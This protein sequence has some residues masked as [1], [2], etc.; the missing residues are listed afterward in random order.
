MNNLFQ[1][2]GATSL[3][4]DLLRSKIR[5]STVFISSIIIY[6]SCIW[7]GYWIYGDSPIADRITVLLSSLLGL[8]MVTALWVSRGKSSFDLLAVLSF[9]MCL[10]F[11]PR[12]IQYVT[13]RQEDLKLLYLL[14]PIHWTADDINKGL[15]YVVLGT[16]MI[17]IGFLGGEKLFYKCSRHTPNDQPLGSGISTKLPGLLSIILAGVI[18]Y[19]VDGYYTIYL[20]LSASSNCDIEGIPY[21]W[22]IHFFSGDVYIFA[23]IALLGLQLKGLDFKYK[24]L[25]C[26]SLFLYLAYC[27]M[28]G[29]RGGV[30]RLLMIAFVVAVAIYRDPEIKVNNLIPAAI[31]VLVLSAFTYFVGTEIREIKRYSCGEAASYDLFK[32]DNSGYEADPIFVGKFRGD[33]RNEIRPTVPTGVKKILDRLGQ[34]D[35]PIGIVA[36]KPN[37][38]FKSEYI[39]FQYVLKN[40][41]NNVLLGVP[42][43]EAQLMTNNMFP[44]LYR[45]FNVEHIKENFLSEPFTI[46]GLSFIF[47]GYFGGLLFLLISSIFIQILYLYISHKS[48]RFIKGG[49]YIFKAFFLWIIVAGA[50][51]NSF[52]FDHTAIIFIYGFLQFATT[53]LIIYSVDKLQSFFRIA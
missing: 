19:C 13:F 10:Y 39:N 45:N 5:F 53:F 26:F 51:L 38:T 41:T 12:L 7:L 29:S 18:I 50:Y 25:L 4:K 32:P 34:I 36:V 24:L 44:L 46:W 6:I 15:T 20:G 37:D 35:Y 3:F 9:T 30:L 47:F 16:L 23:V 11:F 27:L 43:P 48:E 8:I 31:I 40:I 2:N 17:V 21:K 1:S 52:G 49:S 42:Y 22:L 28:L 33:A 14:F